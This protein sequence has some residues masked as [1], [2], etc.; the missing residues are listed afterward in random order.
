MLEKVLKR[1][2][3]VR[4]LAELALQNKWAFAPST[5]KGAVVP[6]IGGNASNGVRDP[7][8]AFG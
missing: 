1:E 7:D 3:S 2:A 4:G 8:K 6:A 5:S